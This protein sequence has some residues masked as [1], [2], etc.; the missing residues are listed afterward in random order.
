MVVLQCVLYAVGML[1]G[2]T[3]KL[4]AIDNLDQYLIIQVLLPSV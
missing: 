4:A 1:F 3:S 2:A